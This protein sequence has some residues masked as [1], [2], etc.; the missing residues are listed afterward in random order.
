M[1][2]VNEFHEMLGYNTMKTYERAIIKLYLIYLSESKFIVATDCLDNEAFEDNNNGKKEILT[3]IE[4]LLTNL[5]NTKN[6]KGLV[7]VP[8]SEND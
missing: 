2:D 5:I 6:D 3:Q 7:V 1:I 4:D 8:S